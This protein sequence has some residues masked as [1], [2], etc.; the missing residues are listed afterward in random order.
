[1]KRKKS[2]EGF[3]KKYIAVRL[4]EPEYEHLTELYEKARNGNEG[5]LISDFMR[6]QLLYE[7]SESTYKN[8][9][10]ELR[11][12]KTELHQALAYSR[13]VNDED[14]VKNLT[15]AVDAAEGKVAKMREVI[16]GWQQQF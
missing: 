12:I 9:L 5:L 16:N 4:T 15:A 13:S 8:M 1:M 14:A 2:P 11:K 10:N 3:R 6:S 7:N